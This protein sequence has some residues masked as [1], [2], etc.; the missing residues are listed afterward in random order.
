MAV[1]ITHVTAGRAAGVWVRMYVIHR[2]CA[3]KDFGGPLGVC[4]CCAA[5]CCAAVK[6]CRAH[7]T[8]SGPVSSADAC[9]VL[10]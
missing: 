9:C 7:I 4:A 2:V 1:L 3:E 6:L 10:R 5:Q 8:A